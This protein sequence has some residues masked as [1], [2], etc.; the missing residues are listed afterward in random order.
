MRLADIKYHTCKCLRLWLAVMLSVLSMSPAGA[1]EFRSGAK[2]LRPGEELAVPVEIDAAGY[3]LEMRASIAGNRN[4]QG[5]G[6]PC[7]CVRWKNR[8]GRDIRELQIKWGNEYLGDPFDR[9][10]MVVNI[11]SITPDGNRIAL[12]ENRLY[13]GVSLFG[14]ENYLLVE[15]AQQLMKVWVGEET[16]L[17][18]G[19]CRALRNAS[20]IIIE[21]NRKLDVGYVA[22][23]FE[24]D[25]SRP[26]QTSFTE[27]DINNAIAVSKDPLVGI[28]RFLDRDTDSRW[29]E[30]GG[31]YRLAVVRHD[32]ELCHGFV[33]PEDIA[34]KEKPAYDI[35]YL[36]GARVKPEGWKSGM[37]KGV[38]FPT[39][40]ENHYTLLWFDA[41]YEHM[42]QEVTADITDA[43]VLTLNFPLFHAKM[44]F[45]KEPTVR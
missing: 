9:R 29:A 22:C 21:S 8:E 26:L 3:A 1:G 44:R 36:E 18:A 5:I 34:I 6:E 14:D 32:G 30:I 20:E 12:S 43:A 27:E 40:F 41:E 33:I 37:L 15:N 39:I 31:S 25:R 38:L 28:W 42:G 35:I 24:P 13:E 2:R 4:V 23:S 11:D 7:W 17:S 19:S 10:F 16:L 45:S